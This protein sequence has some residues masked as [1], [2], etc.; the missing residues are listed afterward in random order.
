MDPPISVARFRLV[1]MGVG[2]MGS[3]RLAP[4][5]LLVEYGRARSMIDG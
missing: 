3:P 1:L 2:A 4:P 5:G